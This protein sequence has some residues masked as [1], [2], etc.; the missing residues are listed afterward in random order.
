MPVNHAVILSTSY[1]SRGFF[2][3]GLY[4]PLWTK[5]YG[6]KERRMLKNPLTPF[7]YLFLAPRKKSQICM[8][9]NV[10]FVVDF[11]SLTKYP[12]V[13]FLNIIQCTGYQ[14]I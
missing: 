6:H 10:S 7:N 14:K 11:F 13:A 12:H 9:L 5:N 2:N 4:P 8:S 3:T 1:M